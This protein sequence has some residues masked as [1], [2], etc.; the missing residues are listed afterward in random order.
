MLSSFFVHSS[1]TKSNK[2]TKTTASNWGQNINILGPK[3]L[4]R[5][6]MIKHKLKQKI[7]KVVVSKVSGVR[8]MEEKQDAL[9]LLIWL[10]M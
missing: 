7:I 9:Y 3:Y 5:K 2:T 1:I 10:K 6:P 4:S 8:G